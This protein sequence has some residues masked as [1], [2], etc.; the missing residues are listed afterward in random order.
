MNPQLSDPRWSDAQRQFLAA[1]DAAGANK[2]EHAVPIDRAAPLSARELQPLVDSGVVREASANGYY[3]Y[4]RQVIAND[5]GSA[6]P[7]VGLRT[8]IYNVAATTHGQ[9]P[10]TGARFVKVIVFWIIII[11]IPIVILQVLGNR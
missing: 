4:P 10:F 3:I 6:P 7:K 5:A 9:I 11:L 8:S 2:A 1:L